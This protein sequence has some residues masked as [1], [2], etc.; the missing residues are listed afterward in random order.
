MSNLKQVTRVLIVDDQITVHLGIAHTLH[1]VTHISVEGA[2]ES[3]EEAY[4]WLEEHQVDVVL[5][6]ILMPGQDG[7]QACK[8]ITEHHPDTKVLML[9]TLDKT[10]HALQALKAG[11]SGYLTK[12]CISTEL[13]RAIKMVH[14]GANYLQTS[15]TRK[16][17]ANSD[18]YDEVTSPFDKLSSRE[19]EVAM[20]LIDGYLPTDIANLLDIDLSTVKSCRSSI[21]D[22][23]GVADPVK[24]SR[25][26]INYGEKE[27]SL[28][29]N[30]RQA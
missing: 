11:A 26:A 24:L 22:K 17:A 14:R 10:E 4:E 23:M 7:I 29:S 27:I 19:M 28:C 21:F 13:V 20:L 15:I 18:A 6:D 16:L 3:A 2:V 25:L 12:G 1:P 8:Y 30:I 9:S 5:L